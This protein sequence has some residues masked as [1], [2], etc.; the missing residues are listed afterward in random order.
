MEI[1]HQNGTFVY[2]MCV[3]VLPKSLNPKHIDENSHIFDFQLSDDQMSRLSGGDRSV[4]Y[5]WDPSSVL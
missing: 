3:G 5:C 4:H 2:E 1:S